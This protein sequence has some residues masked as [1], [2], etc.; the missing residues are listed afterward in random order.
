MAQRYEYLVLGYD[1]PE[2]T[3]KRSLHVALTDRSSDHEIDPAEVKDI[4]DQLGRVGWEAV[5]VQFPYV[6]KR[7]GSEFT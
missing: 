3:G 6:F 7:A 4:L 5:S 2:L 1:G